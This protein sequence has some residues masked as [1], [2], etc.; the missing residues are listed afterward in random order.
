MFRRICGTSGFE[1]GS[2]RNHDNEL[3]QRFG[4]LLPQIC[5]VCIPLVA[6]QRCFSGHFVELIFLVLHRHGLNID[7]FGALLCSTQRGLIGIQSLPNKFIP[8]LCAKHIQMCIIKSV[9]IFHMLPKSGGQFCKMY[10]FFYE[11]FVG[12]FHHF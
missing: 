7:P 2:F 8:R 1:I 6:C 3:L 11:T 5:L 12:F 4:S 9:R 10:I